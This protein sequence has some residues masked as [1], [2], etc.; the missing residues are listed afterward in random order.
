[1][2]N[3]I[4]GDSK[5]SNARPEKSKSFC[6]DEYHLQ[7][8]LH[9]SMTLAVTRRKNSLGCH[10]KNNG[11]K[12][13][14]IPTTDPLPFKLLVKERKQ[15]KPIPTTDPLPFKLL[16]KERKQDK[17]IPTTDPLP[18]KLLVKERKQDKL[19]YTSDP[20]PFEL[21]VWTTSLNN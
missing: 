12:T 20:L 16:V 13:K 5:C 6:A 21:F 7:V 17:P 10:V 1:M 8:T 3:L 15:D 4:P 18:F 19:I 11:N 9:N 2:K 14:P